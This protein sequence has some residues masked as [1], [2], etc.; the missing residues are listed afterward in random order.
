MSPFAEAVDK[1]DACGITVV[2]MK[3][4]WTTVFPDA[5]EFDN[6]S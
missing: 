6:P 4:A 5:E 1:A 2:S 3:S